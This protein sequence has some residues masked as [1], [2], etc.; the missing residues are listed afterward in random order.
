MQLYRLDEFFEQGIQQLLMALVEEPHGQLV[1][2]KNWI[3][4]K[5]DALL[6]R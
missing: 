1:R 6:L 2:S 4:F 5:P 3:L